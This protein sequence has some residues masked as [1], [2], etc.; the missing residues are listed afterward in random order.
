MQFISQKQPRLL[1]LQR[2]L[3][4]SGSTQASAL[5][6]YMGITLRG[7]IGTTALSSWK[8]TALPHLTFPGTEK[9]GEMKQKQ[10]APG[11]NDIAVQGSFYKPMSCPLLIQHNP[12]EATNTDELCRSHVVGKGLFSLGR[13]QVDTSTW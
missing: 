11:G 8:A 13:S 10:G 4:R 7:A 3:S 6:R 9:V 5:L 12:P 2:A 1:S